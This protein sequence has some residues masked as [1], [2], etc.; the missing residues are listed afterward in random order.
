MSE[1]RPVPSAH[2]R[3]TEAE[4][5]RAAAGAR[6][7]GERRKF[8]QGHFSLFLLL[9]KVKWLCVLCSDGFTHR[10]FQ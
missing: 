10:S 1:A 9:I 6:R 5:T 4:R 3:P 2:T 7:V 8:M